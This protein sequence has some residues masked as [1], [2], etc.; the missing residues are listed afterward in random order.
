MYERCH[1]SYAGPAAENPPVLAYLDPEGDYSVQ[2]LA[3]GPPSVITSVF[4]I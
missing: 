2:K 3:V 4:C 1:F